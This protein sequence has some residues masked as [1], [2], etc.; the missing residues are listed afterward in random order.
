[1][2]FPKPTKTKRGN[3]KRK[4]TEDLFEQ[5]FSRDKGCVICWT[6]FDLDRPHHILYWNMAE[7]WPE[8]NNLDRVVTICRIHHYQL[9]FQWDN[10]YRQFCIDY[11][12]EYY[13]KIQS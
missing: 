11:L 5:A 8:K 6:Q 13:G 4:I 10:D 12:T 3:T 1:M 7:Y 9:H 2:L